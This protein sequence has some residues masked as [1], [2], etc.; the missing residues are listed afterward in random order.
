MK[1]KAL[2]RAK[3]PEELLPWLRP[4]LEGA[5]LEILALIRALDRLGLCQDRPPILNDLAEIDADFAQA[6]WV[7]DQPHPRVDLAAM[8]RDLKGDLEELPKVC[9]Q[10]FG[11]LP[12]ARERI[13]AVAGTILQTL[14]AREAYT[15]IPGRDPA[16][17]GKR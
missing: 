2:G 10:L 3:R 15:D 11:L 4:I 13:L 5:R 17:G 6:L 7:L 8:A 16:A 1:P 14:P 9:E 12:E